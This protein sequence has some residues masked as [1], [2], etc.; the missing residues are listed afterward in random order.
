MKEK[1]L[2]GYPSIDKPWLKYY[3]EEAIHAPLPEC[4]MYEYIW[5][6]NK[7][8]LDD[9]ALIYF[10]KKITYRKMFEMINKT[11]SAFLSLGLKEGDTVTCL[12]LSQPETVYIVYA[13][14][15]IGVNINLVNVLSSE[16]E[17]ENSIEETNSKCII[18][19]NLFSDRLKQ[20]LN[21]SNIKFLI[22]LN[23]SNSLNQ[24]YKFIINKKAPAKEISHKKKILYK[25]FIA[26]AN[27][28]SSKKSDYMSNIITHT[29]GT[30]G[31]PK[32]V[33]LSNN[34]I[35]GL[36]FE[37][38]NNLKWKRQETYMDLVVPFVIYGLCVNIHMPLSLGLKTILIPKADTNQIAD[39][40]YKYKPNHVTS[41]PSYWQPLL[42]SE[43]MKN[44]DFSFL[45]TAGAGGDGMTIDLENQLN[46]FFKEHNS[47]A[48]LL[49]G[50]GMTEVC[51]TVSACQYNARKQGSVGIPLPHNNISIF[52]VETMEEKS[53]NEQGEICILS[54]FVMQEYL[55]K[56]N[57]TNQILRKHNDGQTWL[58][59]GDLGHIDSDGFI[60]I[61][62][63]IKRIILTQLD[64]LGHKV[65]PAQIEN[66]LSKHPLVENVCVV[67]QKHIERNFV[68]VAF[69]SLKQETTEK[70][71][72]ELIDLCSQELPEYAQPYDFIFRDSLPLTPI[73]KVDY[74]A[75]EKEAERIYKEKNANV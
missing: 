64:N 21:K 24:I 57:E 71:K 5:A 72:K 29:G 20:I 8:H 50:Y 54:P 74:K 37:Y 22:E 67:A 10:N 17:I 12:V 4:S 70:S 66:I 47:N 38:K 14:N 45:I 23:L 62:G 15:K 65:F 2:T 53:F 13:L 42:N 40:F 26:K 6:N 33:I 39:F 68:P 35:N 56:E 7:D 52:D 61:D 58:H 69:M 49:N 75:L 19:L 59:T 28:Q 36:A 18:S 27:K 30:T 63:R 9:L 41:I 34:A 43:K 16:K 55:K 51:S 31:T 73:G 44:L 48:V 25:D 11:A 46:E 1:E 3:T 60:F 32:G